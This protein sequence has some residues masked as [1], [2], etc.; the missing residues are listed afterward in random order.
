MTTGWALP[1]ELPVD[2]PR[3]SC[4]VTG[5][6][7]LPEAAYPFMRDT[8]DR[9]LASHLPAVRLIFVWRTSGADSLAGRYA[10]ER[11]LAIDLAKSRGPE[12]LS[13]V[14]AD[15][16]VVFSGGGTESEAL[17]RQAKALGIPAR[18]IEVRQY[19]TPAKE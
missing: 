8:L 18:R 17:M 5:D 4:F 13:K 16:L 11:K 1:P 2:R 6:P 15:A 9:L 19:V 14:S 7:R 12:V 10:R 3:F